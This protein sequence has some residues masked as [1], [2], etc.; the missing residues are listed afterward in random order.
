DVLLMYAECIAQSNGDLSTAVAQVDRVRTRVNMPNLSVN[1][2]LS[3]TDRNEFLKRL[4]T[5]R[6]LELATEGHRWADIKRWGLVD[7]QAGI[8]ELKARDPD[9]NNFVIGKSKVLPIPSNEDNN[10]PNTDQNPNY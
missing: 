7:N 3:T 1:H 10:N 4:Q 2:A 5:E 9:F 6:V 8:D